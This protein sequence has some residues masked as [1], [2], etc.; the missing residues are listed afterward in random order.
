M[1][2]FSKDT[3]VFNPNQPLG[4]P[5]G[6]VRAVLVLMIVGCY[7]VMMLL[8]QKIPDTLSITIGVV[9]TFYFKER[10]GEK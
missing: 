1:Q 2:I 7:V 9:I 3:P 10:G 6:T 5:E 8:G 4:M